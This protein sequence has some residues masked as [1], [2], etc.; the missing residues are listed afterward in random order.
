ME[1]GNPTSTFPLREHA[2]R[3]Q[4]LVISA[5]HRYVELLA[6][7]KHGGD[8]K[9]DEIKLPAGNLIGL[10]RDQVSKLRRIYGGLGADE[11]VTIVYSWLPMPTEGNPI[12]CGPHELAP[13]GG[14]E[15]SA[16]IAPRRWPLSPMA[17][18]VPGAPS[19]CSVRPAGSSRPAAASATLTA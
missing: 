17:G 5:E 9:S 6:P 8:R 16:L 10:P 14:L 4:N 15:V 2:V 3:L 12:D 7:A 1:V 11:R 19:T 18:R 13:S